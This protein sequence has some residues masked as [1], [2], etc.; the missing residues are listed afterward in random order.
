V[1]R[2]HRI[3]LNPNNA[4]ATYFAKACGCARLAFNWGL[5]EWQRQHE[6]GEKPSAYGIKKKFNGIKRTQFPFVLE[7]TKWAPE[8]AFRNL[9]SAFRHFFSRRNGHPQF[10]KKSQRDSFYVSGSV[11]KVRGKEVCVPRL[12]WVR[13]TEALRFSGKIQ[14]ATFF[15]NADQWFVS[16]RIDTP[17]AISGENQARSAVGIDLG[18]SR[19]ATLS[20]GS[21]YENPKVTKRFAKRLRRANQNLA[22]KQKG[23]ANFRKAKLRLQKVHQRITD[24]RSDAIHKFTTGVSRQFT[25][26]CL[27]DLNAAGMV[28]NRKLAKAII[29]VSFYQI[30]QQFMYKAEYVHQVDRWFP[31]TKLCSDCGQLQQLKLSDRTH[32]CDCGRPDVDRDLNAAHNILRQGLPDVTPVERKA[33]VVERN[34]KYETGLWEAGTLLKTL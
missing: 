24:Y 34:F 4:Q 25:D 9:D 12:G 27:E 2:A 17:D 11:I 1:H 26:V 7:V 23:S 22:R 19:L 32:K 6:A 33:L 10:K 13:M 15:K 18:V 29:D 3:R 21:I 8:E 5:A 16:F 14:S 30:K 28:K 31:S 20:D